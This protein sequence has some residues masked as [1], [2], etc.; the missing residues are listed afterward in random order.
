MKINYIGIVAS[1]IAFIS[2]ALPWW[3]MA[4]SV[5][6]EYMGTQETMSADVSLY[7]Y[8]ARSSVKIMIV[9]TRVETSKSIVDGFSIWYG[10]TA[11]ALIA[12]ASF[13]G[14]VGSLIVG[15]NGK[16]I[17]AVTG[18]LAL[19]SII[20]FAVGLQ[21]ELSRLNK[22]AGETLPDFAELSLVPLP[23][24]SLFSSNS[25]SFMG[26]SLSYSSYLTF[27]FWLALIAAIT[28]F[29]SLGKH[30]MAPP[31]APPTPKSQ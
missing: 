4:M 14:I 27:G 5:T 8:D 30:P 12:I 11:L 18:I 22:T 13:T 26:V 7:T 1:I 19:V 10:Y 21:S 28:A 31:V 9:E 25:Y 23:Q 2:L 24:L 17:L 29:T 15:K 6:G 16:M 20:I 3:I